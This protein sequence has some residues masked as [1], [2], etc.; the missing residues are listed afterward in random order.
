MP[1]TTA[2]NTLL[3]GQQI[4]SYL[5]AL[6]YPSTST[7]VYTLANLEAI[8]DITDY[9]ANGGICVEVY[10]DGDGSDRRGFGGRIWDPQMWIILSICSLDSPT[11]AETIYNARDALVV[12]FQTHA[13]LGTSVFN[14]FYSELQPNMKFGRLLRNGKW[15]RVHEAHL[16]T[17]QEWYA[18]GG[19]QS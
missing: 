5:A 11:L 12:P 2:P 17:K 14:L 8:K 15:Y 19:I 4:V 3:I 7:I 16:M 6:T 1:A 10:A 9:V 18:S 13:T